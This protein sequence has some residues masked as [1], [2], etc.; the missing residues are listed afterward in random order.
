MRFTAGVCTFAGILLG[1]LLMAGVGDAIADGM[2][3][4][5]PQFFADDILL[6]KSGEVNL[7]IS[8]EAATSDATVKFKSGASPTVKFTLGTDGSDSDIL[9]IETGDGLGAGTPVLK[10]FSSGDIQLGNNAE[11]YVDTDLWRVGIGTSAPQAMFHLVGDQ[12]MRPSSGNDPGDLIFQTSGGTQKG[13]IWAGSGATAEL[14]LSSGDNTADIFIASDGNV[15]VGTTSPGN[16]LDVVTG[17]TT[18]SEFHIGEAVDEGGYITSIND[19]QMYLSAGS[20]YVSSTWYARSTLSSQINMSQGELKFFTNA[21]LT[22]GGSFTPT[23]RMTILSDGNVGIGTITSAGALLDVDGNAL[24]GGGNALVSPY[25]GFAAQNNG[26]LQIHEGTANAG[27]TNHATLLLAKNMTG[28]AGTVGAVRFVNSSLATAEKRIAQ[29]AGHTGSTTNSGEML[30]S[31]MTGGTFAERMRL[32]EDGDL[33]IGTTAPWGRVNA[34]DDSATFVNALV[35]DNT[36]SAAGAT[37]RLAV[38]GTGTDAVPAHRG[39]GAGV[40]GNR[41]HPGQLPRPGDPAR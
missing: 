4:F 7:V 41:D 1:A 6:K 13:R 27:S 34:V 10:A 37:T 30:F 17:T 31:T 16:H 39:K 35:G 29:I 21:S 32:D 28:T 26:Y 22:D 33:G 36:N 14:N 11:L 24:M 40:D 5:L 18:S 19:H 23:R 38:R 25:S 12:L 15:G 8:A 9:K 20:E 2:A 3:S